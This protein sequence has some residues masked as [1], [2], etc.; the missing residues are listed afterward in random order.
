M[1][2]LTPQRLIL[3]IVP[4]ALGAWHVFTRARR[5]SSLVR[6]TALDL[7]EY[8]APRRSGWRRGIV[9]VA[10][11]AGISALVGAFARPV[12]ALPVPREQASLVMAIDVSLSMEAADV[13][14]SRLAAA[15]EAATKFLEI[16]PE[17]LRIGLV[18]F[19]GTALPV[20]APT[21]DHSLLQEAV[22][23]LGLGPGTA[24]GDGIYA[25]LAQLEVTG[26]GVAEAP[27]AIVVLSDG[28]T[29]AGRSELDA[30]A[31]AAA[32]KVPIYTVVFGTP[33]GTVT[34]DGEVIPVP[35]AAG[36]LEQVAETTGG[37]FFAT[38]DE[39]G[40]GEIFGSIGTQVGFETEQRE[41]TDW[42]AALGLILIAAAV[43][44]S[45]RWF[46]RLP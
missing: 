6:F 18:A 13:A 19:A 37:Q 33:A 20:L 22:S 29:T 42:F 26:D 8:V 28:E 36:A 23:R 4:A 14:P 41:L 34:I 32:A 45:I 1:S 44:G 27:R 30:A 39:T 25:A 12:V 16:A 46:G 5:S 9:A 2:F 21:E 7:A 10:A 15:Q 3:L 31:A 24:V 38:A 43:A 40:L 11:L 17:Q 35:A